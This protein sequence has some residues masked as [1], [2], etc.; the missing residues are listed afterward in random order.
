[1]SERKI[2]SL[3]VAIMASSFASRL[4]EIPERLSELQFCELTVNDGASTAPA[5]AEYN[6]TFI[7]LETVESGLSHGL[8]L[9]AGRVTGNWTFFSEKRYFVP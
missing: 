6:S 5:A 4:D 1:M 2:I 8:L 9:S 7:Y 3:L